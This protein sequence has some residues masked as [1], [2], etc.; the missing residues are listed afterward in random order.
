METQAPSVY[1][2]RHA[3]SLK[4]AEQLVLPRETLASE[5]AKSEAGDIRHLRTV[6][7]PRRG[8]KSNRRFLARRHETADEYPCLLLCPLKDVRNALCVPSPTPRRR[9]ASGV[10]RLCNFP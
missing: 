5:A 10:Q 4:E 7:R 1:L 8:P 2:G 6:G 9:D 3:E